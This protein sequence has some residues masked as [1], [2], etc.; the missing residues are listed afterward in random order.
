MRVL[1]VRAM[2]EVSCC[3]SQSVLV[4]L[5]QTSIVVDIRTVYLVVSHNMD[6]LGGFLFG[7]Y[8]KTFWN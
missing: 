5:T 4:D 3:M 2:V 6:N 8:Y 1:R 7:F